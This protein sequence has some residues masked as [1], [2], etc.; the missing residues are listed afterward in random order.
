MAQVEVPAYVSN[1][2]V[3]EQEDAI[4]VPIDDSRAVEYVK[5][6]LEQVKEPIAEALQVLALHQQ[7]VDAAVRDFVTWIEG[8]KVY[9]PEG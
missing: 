3:V 5:R 4:F 1:R 6:Q 9:V 2:L 7:D 8:V